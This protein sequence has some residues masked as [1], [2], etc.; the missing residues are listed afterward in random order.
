LERKTGLRIL[1]QS[2]AISEVGS[3]NERSLRV[4][5]D[6]YIDCRDL[7]LLLTGLDNFFVDRDL[8]LEVE[9]KQRSTLAA[10]RAEDITINVG[11]QNL[12]FWFGLGLNYLF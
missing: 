11:E 8:Y 1:N 6:E 10:I 7:E 12:H 3:R 9:T 4:I 2:K 5:W